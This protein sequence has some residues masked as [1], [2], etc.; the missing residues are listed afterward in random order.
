MTYA[1][2]NLQPESNSRFTAALSFGIAN[3][4]PSRRWTPP[5]EAVLHDLQPADSAPVL[6]LS[7][8]EAAWAPTEHLG[9]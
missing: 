7:R 3:P 2:L 6:D 8:T 1:T 5:G 9:L 4:L